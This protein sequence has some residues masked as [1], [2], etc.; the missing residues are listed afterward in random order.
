VVSG[1]R[2][3][4][5]GNAAAIGF[6]DSLWDFVQRCW[7]GDM[8]LRPGV[9]ELVTHLG[10]AAV[11]WNGLMPPHVQAETVAPVSLEPMSDSFE[12]GEF[13]ILILPLY[14]SP[15]NGAGGIFEQSL[16]VAPESSLASDPTGLFSQGS[17]PSTQYTELSQEPQRVAT[18][19]PFDAPRSEPLVPPPPRQEE[20]DEDV[21]GRVPFPH[22][23][24]NHQP[25]PS[26][27]PP[28]ERKGFRSFLKSMF[29]EL[30]GPPKPPR[31]KGDRFRLL[32][33]PSPRSKRSR[34]PL[35][36]QGA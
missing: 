31:D 14:C 12:H 18:T 15:S 4:K 35:P 22:L 26:R 32:S 21:H 34:S 5:P 1:L 2:P 17:A 8:G 23:D 28:Q 33:L 16:S 20:P 25:P 6:S 24:Q 11:D 9:A 13:K 10:Q 19:K 7:H 30:F 3:T 27:L 36:G 29:Y